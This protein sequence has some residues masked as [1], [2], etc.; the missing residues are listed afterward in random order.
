MSTR[1][2]ALIAGI[3]YLA[4]ALMGFLGIGVVPMTHGPDLAVD[5]QHGMLL[6]LFPVNVLH[7]AV[8]LMIGLWGLY[9]YYTASG[10]RTF[11]K[12]LAVLYAVLA[13]MGFIPGLNTMFGLAPLWGHDI[14]L[15]GLT[16]AVAAYFGWANVPVRRTTTASPL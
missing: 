7:N 15:H 5:A 2:F 3:V 8:H 16:A 14:W 12:G 10:E 13:V 6:G 11:A 9:A 1:I 4:V